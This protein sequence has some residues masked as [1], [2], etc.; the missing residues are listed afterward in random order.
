M[1]PMMSAQSTI[2][3]Q[4]LRGMPRRS[5]T[6]VEA[7]ISI[8]LV[9]VMLV[10]AINTLGATAVS[11][12]SIEQ[13]MLGDSLAQDLMAEILN[14]A[15]E[16]PDDAPNFGRESGEGVGSRVSWDD[17][18]DYAGWSKSPPK[19][20]DDTVLS[21]FDAWTRS[22]EVVWV[23][24]ADL[25]TVTGTKTG[26]KRISVTVS[27]NDSPATELV[28]IRTQ[29]WPKG[30]K[31]PGVVVL[32]VV[33]DIDSPTSEESDRQLLME[34]WGYTVNL[35]QASDSQLKFDAAVVDADIAYVPEGINEVDLNTKLRDTL[36]GV[37]CEE[38]NLGAEFGF[39]DSWTD[40]DFPSQDLQIVD[41]THYVT[42]GLAI[43]SLTIFASDQPVHMLVW[44]YADD[45]ETLGRNWDDDDESW[46]RSLAVIET[47]GDIEGGGGDDTAAGRRVRFPWGLA[48]FDIK[49][50][51]KDGR[52]LM[53]R[54][55]EW[56]ARKEQP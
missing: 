20:K 15:Y 13:Q 48:G 29:A 31:D 18:D 46:R 53:K 27:R 11:K 41:N 50:L 26:V 3:R 21:G 25:N 9:G 54:S 30:R 43:G 32:L 7:V 35:I 45:L 1:S 14:E 33:S 36:I 17:V 37:V 8:V 2:R 6:L 10:A 22:V 55:I 49:K 44:P 19:A 51:N 56:A 28:A 12:R 5:F 23:K 40:G 47:G 52:N 16:E 39:A 42:Q 34:S 38:A 4:P 24:P